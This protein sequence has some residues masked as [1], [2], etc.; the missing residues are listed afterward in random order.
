MEGMKKVAD[1][2]VSRAVTNFS[3]LYRWTNP[4]IRPGH[5]SSMPNGLI[6]LKGGDLEMELKSFKDRIEIYPISTWFQESFFS[7]KKIVYLKK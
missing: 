6:S 7:T 4:L 3:Q 1:F 2:V 5:L